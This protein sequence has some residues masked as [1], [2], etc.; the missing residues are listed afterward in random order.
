LLPLSRLLSQTHFCQFVSADVWESKL[1][2][3]L[4]DQSFQPHASDRLTALLL[5]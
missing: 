1:G 3:S 4:G 5:P 2:I